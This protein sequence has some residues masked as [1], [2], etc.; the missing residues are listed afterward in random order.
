MHALQPPDLEQAGREHRAGVPGRDDSVR[1]A[2]ADG[3]VRGDERAVRLRAHRFGGL[4]VHPDRLGRLDELEAA[5]IEPGR[6]EQDRLDRLAPCLERPRD[7]L[8]GGP[9]PAHRVDG[10][11]G[12]HG[13]GAWMRSGSTS[14]P[15]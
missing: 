14:R 10:D 8:F 4:L 5:G 7:D 6:T 12:G 1:L 11:A 9:V 3:T 15:L 2:P 13:Y